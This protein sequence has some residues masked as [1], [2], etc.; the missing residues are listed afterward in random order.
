MGDGSQAVAQCSSGHRWTSGARGHL[1]RIIQILIT[2]QMHRKNTLFLHLTLLEAWPH[3]RGQINLLDLED[4]ED[5][6]VLKVAAVTVRRTGRRRLGEEVVRSEK[7]VCATH[8]GLLVDDTAV[9]VHNGI[10]PHRLVGL[11]VNV[12]L[13]GKQKRASH[14]SP[15]LWYMSVRC[16]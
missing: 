7:V 16:T 15:Y 10:M 6:G 2:N 8:E 9:I 4:V 11:H 3:L 5:D 12:E 14:P 1:E 13:K